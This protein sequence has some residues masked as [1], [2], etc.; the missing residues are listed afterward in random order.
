MPADDG[1]DEW[2]RIDVAPDAHAP[3]GRPGRH[4][5]AGAADRAGRRCRRSPCPTSSSASRTSASTSTRSACPCS[6]R[7]ATSRTGRSS[8]A[9][10]PYRIAPNLM[11]VVPD[12]RPTCHLTYERS[13]LDIFSYLLTFVGLVAARG[14]AAARATSATARHE[15]YGRGRPTPSDGLLDESGAAPRA[16]RPVADRRAWPADRR[17]AD[18]RGAVRGA[19]CRGLECRPRAAAPDPATSP[20]CRAAGRATTPA[21]GTSVGPSSRRNDPRPDEGVGM[22][23]PAMTD[24]ARF[25]APARCGPAEPGTSTRSSRPTTS[26]APSPTSSTPTSP[27]RSA[28]ASPASPAPAAVLV[29][30]DMRPSGPELVDAFAR[31]VMEQGVDVVDLGLVSTD[32]MYYAAGTLDAPGAV[33]TASHNPAQYNG[34]KFC[35]VGRP[36]GRPGHRA[37]RGQGDRAARCSTGTARCRRATAGSIDV[38]QPARGVRRPRRLVHRHRRRCGRCASSPTRRTAWAASSSR[39]CSSGSRSSRSR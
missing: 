5:Q 23:D 12:R 39:R 7:S 35:L 26:G 34:V 14:L 15:P 29:G 19:A 32:L 31:G 18:R 27:T 24:S 16:P 2:Q 22:V 30:R 6:S 4:R 33:F 1:P 36:S 3:P 17:A 10:G 20:T 13:A 11:V 37:A 8:G 9:E 38:A 21:R 28:S 25:D